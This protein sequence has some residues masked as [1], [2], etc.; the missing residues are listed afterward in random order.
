[1]SNFT[2]FDNVFQK[3]FSSPQ[4]E[5]LRVSY[6]DHSMSVVVRCPFTFEHMELFAL[7]LEKLLFFTLFNIYRYQPISTKLGRN[8][9]DHKI[10][11]EFDYGFNWTRTSG[12]IYPWIRNIA[13]FH[14]V[15][16]PASTNMNQSAPNLV[17]VYMTIRYWMSLIMGLIGPDH[18]ELFALEWEKYATFDIFYTLASTN[19]NQSA[20]NLVKIYTRFQ[21]K[22]CTWF[23]AIFPLPNMLNVHVLVPKSRSEHVHYNCDFQR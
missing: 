19:I 17:K 8:I 11:D 16:T 20:P 13:I 1:M 23:S 15:Y 4:H 12:V 21:K 22:V 9:C 6:R 2:F 10:S 5:V 18:L 7:E 14:F 3:L